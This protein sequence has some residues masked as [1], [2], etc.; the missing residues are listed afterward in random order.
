MDWCEDKKQF[1][2]YI[3][4]GTRDE[5]KRRSGYCIMTIKTKLEAAALVQFYA[6]IC[7]NRANN[8]EDSYGGV[9]AAL[10]A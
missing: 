5:D 1:R 2:V 4:T 3:L 8:K 10:F 7:K 9:Q 6:F